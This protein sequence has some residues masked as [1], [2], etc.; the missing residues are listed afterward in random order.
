M[1]EKESILVVDDDESWLDFCRT[2]LEG[3]GYDF[4]IDTA[5]NGGQALKKIEAKAYDVVLTDL[6]MPPPDGKEL[7]LALKSRRPETDAILM[8]A[9]LTL[10]SA[11]IADDGD[12]EKAG[13][14]RPGLR[15]SLDG[16]F[17]GNAIVH[18]DSS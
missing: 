11:P 3:N 6:S 13:R 7:V 16:W 4:E 9:T 18:D 10:E 5:V 14:R 17:R 8:T 12:P 1:A 15:N 2:C